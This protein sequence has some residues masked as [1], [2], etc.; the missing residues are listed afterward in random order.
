MNYYLVLFLIVMGYMTA[1]FAVSLIVKRNDIAD[2]AWGI[3]F[4]LLAWTSY[5]LSKNTHWS[6]ILVNSLVTI[7]GLRLSYHIFNRNR[8]K[9]EDYRY[10]EW[11]KQWGRLFYIKSFLQVFV[12]QGILLFLIS[13]PVTILNKSGAQNVP[14]FAFVG[15][16]IWTIGFIFESVGDDQLSK[17]IKNPDNGGKVLNTGLWKYSRH[18]NYF[19]EVTQWWGIWIISVCITNNWFTIVGP[20]LITFLILKVSGIPLLEEKMATQPEYG[21]YASKTSMFIPW[22][23]KS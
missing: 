13:I 19:G 3:G 12:L 4:V 16:A 20:S 18:P 22:F 8:K 23:P 17:F 7:W 1:W 21:E 2:V 14:T 10:A 6:H 9:P 15:A 5:F 11:R